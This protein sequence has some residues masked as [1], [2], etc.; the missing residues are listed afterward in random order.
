M[1]RFNLKFRVGNAKYLVSFHDGIKTHK[2]GSRFY[3]IA[4]FKNKVKLNNFI[5]ELK[6][7]GY[8]AVVEA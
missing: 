2:D 3:D 7:Q 8:V 4:I 5:K 1:K 6:S